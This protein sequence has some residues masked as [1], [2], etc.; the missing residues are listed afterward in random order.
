[1][2][3]VRFWDKGEKVQEHMPIETFY[4]SLI[5]WLPPKFHG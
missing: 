3:C 1:M 2:E 4:K 5:S